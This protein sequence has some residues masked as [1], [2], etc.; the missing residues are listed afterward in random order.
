MA[1]HDP[2]KWGRKSSKCYIS[3][4]DRIDLIVERRIL[5]DI[6]KT[7]NFTQLSY[8]FVYF[9]FFCYLGK[10]FFVSKNGGI[11]CV[12][13]PVLCSFLKIHYARGRINPPP[14]FL[15]CD[16]LFGQPTVYELWSSDITQFYS[17][18]TLNKILWRT[19]YSPH[20]SLSGPCHYPQSQTFYVKIPREQKS[21][22]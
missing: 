4:F 7:S 17:K 5:L 3:N 6:V 1:H 15:Q 10:F 14:F 2:Q 19:F 18:G 13:G 8:Y 16:D 11:F 20:P 12:I 9:S 22:L 21:G